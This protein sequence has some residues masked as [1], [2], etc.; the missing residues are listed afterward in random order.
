MPGGAPKLVVLDL[1]ENNITIDGLTALLT[2]FPKRDTTEQFEARERH[3][4]LCVD[5]NPLYAAWESMEQMREFR[6]KFETPAIW[7]M[8]HHHYADFKKRGKIPTDPDELSKLLEGNGR[9][10]WH[11]AQWKKAKHL[12]VYS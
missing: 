2:A 7:A 11:E 4:A 8:S 9:G 5:N 12:T 10:S 6:A 3:F 1:M